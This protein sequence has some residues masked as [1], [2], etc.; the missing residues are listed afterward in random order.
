MVFKFKHFY[1]RCMKAFIK[2]PLVTAEEKEPF[3]ASIQNNPY[4]QSRALWNDVYGQTEKQLQFSVIVNVVL[5]LGL[6]VTI[7]GM[8]FLANQR[9]IKPY[10]FIIHG[11]QVLTSTEETE[12]MV[13]HLKPQL[14]NMLAK[15]FIRN[16]RA[17]ST[18]THVNRERQMASF[19]VLNQ[20]AIGVVDQ[21]FGQNQADVIAKTKI[22]EIKIT[23]LLPSSAQTVVIRWQ[24]IWRDVKTGEI[25]SREYYIA[26]MMYQFDT[27]SI[28]EL[29]LK[30]NPLGFYVTHLTWSL[31]KI[32]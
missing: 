2:N 32:V 14:A 12:A 15:G 18:D 17:V 31:E 28:H 27:P 24:E 23:S 26:E 29:V 19:A 30:Y 21:Y 22:N 7:I 4:L 13:K 25:L 1:Q 20:E 10:P 8:V 16:V 5:V 6:I 9:S 3:H 11:E